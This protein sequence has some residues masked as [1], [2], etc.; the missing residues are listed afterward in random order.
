[1]L[2]SNGLTVVIKREGAKCT[3]IDVGG[4]TLISDQFISAD[5]LNTLL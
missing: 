5:A 4:K 3:V 1:M 2:D